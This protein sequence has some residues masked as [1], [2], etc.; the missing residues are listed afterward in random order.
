LKSRAPFWKKETTAG[1]ERWV[2]R[3]TPGAARDRAVE[4]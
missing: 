2:T 3:N 1:G 4:D